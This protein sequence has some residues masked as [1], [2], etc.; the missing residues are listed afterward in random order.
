MIQITFQLTQKELF[1]GMLTVAKSRTGTKVS[2]VISGLLLLGSVALLLGDIVLN[3]H[4]SVYAWLFLLLC[5]FLT[6]Y[7][8]LLIWFQARKLVK[9]NAQITESVTY[10]FTKTDYELQ[11][12]SYSTR[13]SY[14][15]LVEVREATDFI[16]F[17]ITEA[18]AHIIPKRALAADQFALLK[19]IIQSIPNLK[20][21]FTT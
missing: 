1:T 12:D 2:Q 10:I 5:L 13:M 4:T 11:G 3:Q 21:K 19:A 6:F 15:K 18:S 7:L 17:K 14:A 20:S 8:D 9:L 16:L